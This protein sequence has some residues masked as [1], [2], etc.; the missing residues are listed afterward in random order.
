VPEKS[1]LE[2]KTLEFYMGNEIIINRTGR[3]T[4]V[5]VM[6]RGQLAELHIDRGENHSFIGNV[7]LGKVVR[8]LPG[9]Q[10]AFVEIGLDRAAFLYA[11]DIYTEFIERTINSD[12]VDEDG[13]QTVVETTS[14][15]NP[16][17]GIPPISDLVREGQEILVQVSKD[18]IST[19]GARVKT[20]ISLPGR[21]TVCMPTVDNIGISKKIGKDKERR[22]L[23]DFVQ[24]H[25]QKGCGFIVRTICEGQ[26]LSALEQDMD[27]LQGTWNKIN[28]N[29][30]KASAPALLH[31]DQNLALRVV[32]DGFTDDVERLFIDDKS[33]YDEVNK[34][35]GVFAGHLKSRIRLYK[36]PQPIFDTF[37]IE[38]M[39][40]RTLERKVWLKSGGY[41]IIDQTEALSAIDVNSGKF[42][43]QKT[44][45]DTTLLI[46]LEAVEEICNQLRLRNIGGI[47]VLDFID[48]EKLENRERVYRFM[49]EHLRKDRAR[50]NL[51]KISDLG[52][53][54]MT[55]KRVQEDLVSSI[56]QTCPYCLGTGSIRD[57]QTVVYDV[58]REIKRIATRNKRAKSI[59]VNANPQVA[60]MLY[61][62]ELKTIEL[63]EKDFGQRVVVRAL[64]HYH[65]QQFEVYAR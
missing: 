59:F 26:P 51:L 2:I 10:A 29:K 56:S 22:K 31:K 60:D 14:R 44:L 7:Y 21:F 24:K 16:N 64:G 54:E 17:K 53:I 39:I 58:I 37:N 19:K 63:M 4:R 6:E 27:Y 5:A 57:S 46:N 61:S 25:R 45:E 23:R 33:L 50:T 41:L 11:G 43:G 30:E 13:D 3:E 20:H 18:P 15:V 62:L 49:E 42:V 55:R 12:N 8:V 1:G 32:R 47:I 28:V 9:M 35:V 40:V 38:P 36:N 52:L 48:M 34:F 65:I